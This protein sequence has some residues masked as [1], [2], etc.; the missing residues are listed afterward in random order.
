MSY[1]LTSARHR[2]QREIMQSA[3]N[4][5]EE[6]VVDLKVDDTDA[7]AKWENN[8]QR[9]KE[10]QTELKALREAGE[11]GSEGYKALQRELSGVKA[12]QTALKHDIDLSTASINQMQSALSYWVNQAKKAEQGSEEWINATKKID[13]IRPVLNDARQELNSFGVEVEKQPSMWENFKVS[14]LSVFTGV[15]L[16]ELFK[17][18]AGAVVDFGKE[19]FEITAR[20]EKYLAVLTQATGSHE[21][22]KKAMEDIKEL[23]KTT[24]MSVDELTES[25]V[26][27]ANRG[28]QPTMQE[29]KAM[30]DVAA[31]S[32]KSFEQ[33]TEALLDGATG[34]NERFK[35][36]GI[37]AESMGD[38][39]QLSFKGT[40]IT[41]DKSLEGMNEAMLYFQTNAEGVAGATDV[42]AGTMEGKMNN[43]GDAFDAFKLVIGDALIPVFKFFLDLAADGMDLITDLI[44]GQSELSDSSSALG[45][46]WDGLVRVFQAVWDVLLA[47][48][49][50]IIDTISSLGSFHQSVGTATA[51]GWL[52]EAVLDAIALAVRAVGAV[53]IGAVGGVQALYD[54]FNAII[55]KGKELINIF[56]PGT[57]KI[58]PA[59]SFDTVAKNA[60][61][62]LKKIEGLFV[63]T[64][65]KAEQKA[66]ST[67]A[68]ITATENAENNKQVANNQKANDTKAAA[69]KKAA[70]Q[71]AKDEAALTKKL[72][73]MQIKAIADDTK[74][75]IAKA[76]L[77]Y[78]RELDGINK[79]KASKA[80]KDKAI[81]AA[82][83]LHTAAIA[84]INSD[85]RKKE[86]KEEAAAKKKAA[87]EQKKKEQEEKKYRDDRLKA[88]KKLLDDEFK[89][90]V[91]NAKIDLALTKENSQA[92]WDAKKKLL[93]IENAHKNRLLQ[94]EAAAEKARIQ[95][96][97]AENNRRNLEILASTGQTNML[98]IADNAAMAA[99]ISAIDNRLNAEIKLNDQN[100]QTAKTNLNREA[101]AARRQNNEEFYSALNTAMTG[102]MNAFMAFLQKKNQS[103]A[104]SLQK[105]LQDNMTHIKGVGDAMTT[106]VNELIKLNADYTQKKLD[107][108]KKEYDTNIA[109]LEAEYDKGLITEEEL[110]AGKLAIQNDYDAK[111]AELKRKEFERNKKLQIANALIA[112][113]MAVLSALATPPF[114]VGLALAVTAAAK[115]A[116]DIN[117]IKN[118]KFEGARG[119]VFKNAGVAQGSRHG[120]SYGEGGIAMY[121]RH[122]GEEVG[123]IEG[124]E[125]VMVLSRNT[126]RNNKPVIDRLLNSSLYRNGAP[127]HLERGG[128]F[129]VTGAN[130][131]R[132]R[133]YA[134]GGV[135]SYE[136]G[137]SGGIAD[138]GSTAQSN[139]VIAEN[140]KI[141]NEMKAFQER[142]AKATE[143]I[144]KTLS[145]HTGIL[146]A[147][148][149]KDPG[150]STILHAIDRIKL[151]V[152][153]ASA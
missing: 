132:N 145:Q 61:A 47:V 78:K 1:I 99:Q 13:E 100:T 10:I 75:A 63:G 102:D 103:E 25:Y 133:M 137:D 86:E 136:S 90:A 49:E 74:R 84:K 34:Q 127:I 144:A 147:I 109:K 118:Q 141:Q 7:A 72:E 139:A 81:E 54:S 93:D 50:T 20:F 79:S 6:A 97:I 62:N 43:L 153:K 113:S 38:K 15:G 40:E 42:M 92:M 37:Q 53:L 17:S 134:Q 39:V 96:S 80:T 65:D 56:S 60:E 11:N 98:L 105:R 108:L 45:M 119:G 104:T 140:K 114:F 64:Y 68:N 150:T 30:A 138:D 126:Y 129:N 3:M 117:K 55:N 9:I 123:E 89:A 70:D 107:N 77:D 35:E 121:D 33:L 101:N 148:K 29:M 46:I 82:E 152:F 116:I 14:V 18:A 151:N 83:K 106:A 110:E 66:K 5:R 8:K 2:L 24:P 48:G 32:G 73:D 143:D 111:N 135:I 124:G 87:A 88:S 122:T 31:V 41:V 120:S 95:E 28:L 142:T 59:A 91:A 71:K 27:Y 146:N 19:I 22:A 94:Q 115:T 57:F 36:L 58:D 26:K 130:A 76:D 51:T 149:D 125:P 4:I 44:S 131:Y 52:L 85:A 112:G 128:M 12:E 69:N 21:T 23:A 67:N 16:L